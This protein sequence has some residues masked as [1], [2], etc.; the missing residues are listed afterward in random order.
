[1]AFS[2]AGIREALEHL[3]DELVERDVAARITIVGGAAMA[4]VHAPRPSTRDVDA[5]YRPVE[6]VEA[7]SAV[8]GDRH[9][10][11]P[12]WINDDVAAMR[13]TS[14]RSS[15]AV[16]FGALRAPRS[17]SSGTTQTSN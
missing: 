4:L 15:T 2:P 10:Y 1:V 6:E 12:R 3:V 13:P 7:A 14:N 16:E 5:T 11:P 9:G 8:V 17:S